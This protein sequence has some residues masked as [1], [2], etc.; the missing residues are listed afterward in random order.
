MR[1]VRSPQAGRSNSTNAGG[2]S[3]VPG[4]IATQSPSAAEVAEENVVVAYFAAIN[5]RSLDTAW[6]L[7]GDNLFPSTAALIAAY[8]DVSHLD[9]TILG[10]RGHI[11]H[12]RI[13]ATSLTGGVLTQD[14]GFMVEN[15]AIVASEPAP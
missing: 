15:G 12:A 10:V 1:L 14:R 6:S 11:V 4:L 8:A 7:G 2:A 3:K 5:K 9:V 13:I